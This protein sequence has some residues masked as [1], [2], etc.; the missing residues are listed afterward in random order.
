MVGMF[1]WKWNRKGLGKKERG[2]GKREGVGRKRR[3][4]RGRE[5]ASI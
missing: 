2:K 3:E 4:G 1:V 5:M